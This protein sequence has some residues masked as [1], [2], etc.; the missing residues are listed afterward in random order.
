MKKKLFPL[1]SALLLVACTQNV[2][3]ETAATANDT[4]KTG[5]TI[6]KPA[7]IEEQVLYN[8][9]IEAT[10]WGV[11]A[12]SM[13]AIRHSLKRDLDANFGDIVYFSKVLE[14]RHEL[15][16]ANNQTPYVL[17]FFDLRNGPMVLQVPAATKKVAFFGSAIDS[18]EVPIADIGPAGE[19]GGKRR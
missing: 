6:Y 9:A 7:N 2:K 19:D 18:W 11:P 1:L 10:L 8:R 17:T 14:A 16:T 3:T 4:E 15:L 12:V 5:T 13:V